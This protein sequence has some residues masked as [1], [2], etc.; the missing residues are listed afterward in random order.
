[1][2]R[3]TIITVATL[4]IA[5]PALAIA[6]KVDATAPGGRIREVWPP[7]DGGPTRYGQPRRAPVD[8]VLCRDGRWMVDGRKATRAEVE[9]H[10]KLVMTNRLM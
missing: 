4:L 2:M 6:C 7:E 3:A 5:S 9:R 8:G 10:L 1:M